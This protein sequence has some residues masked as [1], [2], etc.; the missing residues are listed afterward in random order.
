MESIK[1]AKTLLRWVVFARFY[2]FIDILHCTT[3]EQSLVR[4]AWCHILDVCRVG[5]Y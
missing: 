4:Q 3:S 2:T 5:I 1:L